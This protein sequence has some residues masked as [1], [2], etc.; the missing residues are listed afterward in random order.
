MKKAALIA[1]GI[2]SMA[3]SKEKH[4]RGIGEFEIGADFRSLP[5]SEQ[6]A[7]ILDDEFN[8]ASI[9]FDEIGEVSNFHVTTCDGK[10]CHVSF[11]STDRTNLETLDQMLAELQE[12][13]LDSLNRRNNLAVSQ[14]DGK[15][16]LSPNDSVMCSL[17][18][19]ERRVPSGVTERT[20]SYFNPASV[21]KK[22]EA[23]RTLNPRKKK[24]SLE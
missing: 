18:Y 7:M 9:K 13:K 6:F 12:I 17:I 21:M 19:G 14:L 15:F 23:M 4:F 1:L 22:M 20:Y 3:C 10:I 8:I 2:L 24:E 5:S 16:Y 11:S